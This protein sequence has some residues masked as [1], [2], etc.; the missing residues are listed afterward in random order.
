MSDPREYKKA[1]NVYRS[2]DIRLEIDA[3]M[4]MVFEKLTTAEGLNSWWT[5]A[6]T[7]EARKGGN[8]TYVWNF[9]D[10]QFIAKAIYQRFKQP[11]F[12]EVEYIEWEGPEESDGLNPYPEPIM[13][14][15]ELEETLEGKT[16]LLIKT[17]GMYTAE[18]FDKIFEENRMGWINSLANLKSVCETGVDIREKLQDIKA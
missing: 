14:E 7:A 4:G 3:P 1:V 12:F 5:D 6:T 2:F 8:I 13:H 15:Y 18:A 16:L 9:N 11:E 17:A 10:N